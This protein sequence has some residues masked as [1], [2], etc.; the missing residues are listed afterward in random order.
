[1]KVNYHC[2]DITFYFVRNGVVAK[3]VDRREMKL[4]LR[5]ENYPLTPSK[6]IRWFKAMTE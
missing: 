1:M 4:S 6:E 3:T 2:V 5:M